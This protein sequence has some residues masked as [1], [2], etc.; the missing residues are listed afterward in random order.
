MSIRDREEQ[1]E[2]AQGLSAAVGGLSSADDPFRQAFEQA[3]VGMLVIDLDGLLLHANRAVCELFGFEREEL[4]GR[5]LESLKHP[6]ETDLDSDQF[7]KLATGELSRIQA[8]RRYIHRCGQSL[9]VQ[10]NAAVV[11]DA[12]GQPSYV[13]G[14]VHSIDDRRKAES[15]LRSLNS[16][17]ARLASFDGLTGLMNRR[18]LIS[19]FEQMWLGSD[20]AREPLSCIILDIDHFKLVNDGHG[21]AAG[22]EVLR[23]VGAVLQESLRP[24]HLVGRWGGEEFLMICTNTRAD[25]AFQIAEGIRAR[26]GQKPIVWRDHFL[27]VTVSLGVAQRTIVC[28]EPHELIMMADEQLYAAKRMGRNCTCL[29]ACLPDED[30][31][32]DS[33]QTAVFRPTNM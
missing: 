29:A 27:P 19:G 5:N 10:M 23:Y 24:H 32:E 13:V 3:G 28:Q 2:T 8:E 20:D 30:S 15:D 26:I 25:D 31:D 18:T 12:Q 6:E 33:C 1:P 7:Q 14:H 17:L 11:R 22:D 21:H 16:Q 4:L 9:W